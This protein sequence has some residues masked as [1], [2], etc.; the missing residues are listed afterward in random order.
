MAEKMAG[1][2]T[3]KVPA[4]KLRQQQR[5]QKGIPERKS[6]SADDDLGGTRPSQ[7]RGGDEL[8]GGKT[9][10]PAWKL[11][12]RSKME[13]GGSFDDDNDSGSAVSSGSARSTRSTFSQRSVSSN[14]SCHPSRAVVSRVPEDPN[15]PPA[16]RAMVRRKNLDDFTSQASVHSRSRTDACSRTTANSYGSASFE[17]LDSDDDSFDDQ[18]SFASLDSD[19]DEDDEA[20]RESKNQLARLKIQQEQQERQHQDLKRGGKSRYKKK[21]MGTTLDFIA[22]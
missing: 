2:S 17:Y 21:T 10:L 19:A 7:S 4:W 8:G 6:P 16:F 15:L 20:Y 1:S 22:E 18:D 5:Q 14:A 11:R 12:E 9:R 13:R 3:A